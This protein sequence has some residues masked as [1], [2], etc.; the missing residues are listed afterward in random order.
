MFLL[1]IVLGAYFFGFMTTTF[2][3]RSTEARWALTSISNYLFLQHPI[4]GQGVG[5]FVS[6]VS[7]INYFILEFGTP[8]D[9]HGLISKLIA[10]QG[11]FGLVAFGLFIIWLLKFIN[12]SFKQ[13]PVIGL[14]ALFLALSPLIF[15][16]FNTQYYSSKMWVPIMLSVAIVNVF[17]KKLVY[18][19]KNN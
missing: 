16:L 3:E 13:K 4:L 17:D 5:T 9:A 18:E 15:Q 8:I 19:E 14:L 2:V 6:R 7:E 12:R 11:L 10:E 1:V